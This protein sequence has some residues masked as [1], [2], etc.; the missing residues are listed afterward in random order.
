LPKPAKKE[1]PYE[2]LLFEIIDEGIGISQENQIHLFD[3][4]YQ[5][6][7]DP[8]NKQ[9]GT[10][11]GLAICKQLVALWE[12]EIGLISE[13]NKGSNFWFTLPLV[14][15]TPAQ[16]ALEQEALLK[17][18]KRNI[19]FKDLNVLIAEDIFV[20]QEVAKTMIEQLGCT[21]EI[22]QNGKEAIEMAKNKAYHLILMDIQM[23][24]MNGIAATKEIK[25]TF[26]KAPIIIGVSA[27]AM[28]EDAK[29][30]IAEGMDDYISKPIEPFLLQEKLAKWFP[31]HRENAENISQEL[32]NMETIKT[33]N[34]DNQV[35]ATLN[36]T[37]ITKLLSLVKHN[38]VRF[39]I[40]LQSFNEDMQ[41]LISNA[42]TAIETEDKSKLISE[43]HT[44]K[45]V[46]A[47]IGTSALHE[48]TKEF[49]RKIR[50]DNFENALQH[51]Q[52]IEKLYQEASL[53][54][55]EISE[56]L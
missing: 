26:E 6:D 36:E 35:I 43:I 46:S 20:N 45:G 56:K 38:K 8:N 11:L 27:N 25:A 54:L 16:I 30:Y 5:V 17:L 50:N 33:Q 19:F 24:I 18:H 39:D 41:D 29:R 51:I 4:F 52:K 2:M 32:E 28:E 1:L 31:S 15:A 12:G 47:T 37:V 9:Q 34:T 13:E 3:K 48:E 44:I 42:K 21:A 40:L 23:P 10:G 14:L 49:Y 53:A 7:L 22:A 55:N